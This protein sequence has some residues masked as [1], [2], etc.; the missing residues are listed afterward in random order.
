MPF[1]NAIVKVPADNFAAGLSSAIGGGGPDLKMALAQHERYCEALRGCGLQLT[2][3]TADVR[4]PDSTFIEDTAVLTP[5]AAIVTRPGAPSR[6]GEEAATLEALRSLFAQIYEIEA[7]GTVDGGDVCEADGDFIIGLS[8]RT[9]EDGA[10]QL[11]AFLQDLGHESLL[12]DIRSCRTL[13]H[14]KSGMSYLGSGVFLVAADVPFADALGRYELITVCEAE[15]YAANCVR[16]NDRILMAAGYPRLFATLLGLGYAVTALE[17]SE[18]RK[19]DGG[20]SCLS[21]RF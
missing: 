15:G 11:A 8:A 17:M 19:M 1:T 6:L 20:L 21:L 10:R 7:P 13:L 18:F 2:T 14:L 4:H 3:L 16:V 9:N 12:L 5:R